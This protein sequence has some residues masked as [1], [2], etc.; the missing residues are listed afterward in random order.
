MNFAAFNSH[1]TFVE[2]VSFIF[3]Y[4]VRTECSLREDFCT[5]HTPN[6]DQDPPFNLHFM[7]ILK[8]ILFAFNPHFIHLLIL[9]LDV[10]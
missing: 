3:K 6:F 7:S 10:F 9:T 5:C 2:N 4:D 8:F 1:H